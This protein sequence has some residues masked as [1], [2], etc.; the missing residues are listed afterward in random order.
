[1]EYCIQVW[2]PQPKKAVDLLQWVQR[3]AMMM[4]KGIENLSYEERLRE[5][6]MFSLKKRRLWEDLVAVAAC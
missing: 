2:G 3:R 1:M 4:I 5:L 6:V